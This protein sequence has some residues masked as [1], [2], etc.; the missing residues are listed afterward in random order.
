M[1]EWRLQGQAGNVEEKQTRCRDNGEK[2]ARQQLQ[3]LQ[4]A[5]DTFQIN[6][7]RPS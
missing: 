1:Q 4:Q 3:S 6:T 2:W 5:A 7:F